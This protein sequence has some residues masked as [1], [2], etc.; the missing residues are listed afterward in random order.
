[1]TQAGK[2]LFLGP[3]DSP[4]IP[5]LREQGEDVVQTAD[6]LLA[7]TVARQGPGFLVSYGYRHILRKD[8][9]DMFPGKAINLHVSFLPWNRGADPNFWSFVE[10]TPKGVTIHYLDEGVD[11]GDIIVQ[12]K[13]VFDSDRETLATSYAKLQAEIQE[14]F[15]RNWL[16]IKSGNCRR[17]RQ[18]GK[19]STH[20][21]REKEGLSHLLAEGWNTPVSVLEEYAAET[22]MSMRFW[23]KYD[24]EIEEIGRQKRA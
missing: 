1:M 19:G 10:D 6:R 5:W 14:L 4:L 8:I 15:K 22:Q 18:A 17:Q 7:E 11:T 20:R 13:M 21:A 23:D 9:L 24:A 3:G 2:L 16:D 12:A